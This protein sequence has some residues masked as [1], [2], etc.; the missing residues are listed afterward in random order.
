MENETKKPN[1]LLVKVGGWQAV[2]EA[3]NRNP[4]LHRSGKE[5]GGLMDK[6]QR[7]YMDLFD[8]GAV[9]CLA[10]ITWMLNAPFILV[11]GGAALMIG[12]GIDWFGM[13]YEKVK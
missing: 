5:E 11:G 1:P 8:L 10:G 2:C 3:G 9:L 7:H 4:A 6:K 13:R 12:W